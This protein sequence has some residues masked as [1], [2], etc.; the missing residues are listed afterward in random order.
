MDAGPLVY[1]KLTYEG[2]GELKNT[3]PRKGAYSV[4]NSKFRI[5]MSVSTKNDACRVH[6]GD[7][8]L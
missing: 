5:Y 7:R 3:F 1:H 2:S 6:G 8:M 4:N